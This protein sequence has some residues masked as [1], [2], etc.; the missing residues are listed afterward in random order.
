MHFT[1]RAE[2]T[3]S[4]IISSKAFDKSNKNSKYISFN[5]RLVIFPIP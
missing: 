4:S 2:N 1:M 5:F 3:C